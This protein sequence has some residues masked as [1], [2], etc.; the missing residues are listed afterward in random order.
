[1]VDKFR[2]VPFE[3]NGQNMRL[4]WRR[5]CFQIYDANGNRVAH[6]GMGNLPLP[7]SSEAE[8]KADYIVQSANASILPPAPPVRSAERGEMLALADG[9]EE[10]FLNGRERS[11]KELRTLNMATAQLRLAAAPPAAGSEASAWRD[12]MAQLIVKDTGRTADVLI[13]E[14]TMPAS[15]YDKAL[16]AALVAAVPPAAVRDDIVWLREIDADTDNACWVIS[17]RVDP[18]AVPFFS[19]SAYY[20]APPAAGSA[21]LREALRQLLAANL[22]SCGDGS[23]E[24]AMP[25]PERISALIDKILA[26]AAPSETAAGSDNARCPR[27]GG[28]QFISVHENLPDE[29]CPICNKDAPSGAERVRAILNKGETATDGI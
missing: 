18:D 26:L 8:A 9:L 20:S 11:D 29:P 12:F 5:S 15:V 3:H 22:L 19:G 17:N 24:G 10:M 28:D 13:V 2:I 27:C 1:M 7:M 14:Q 25:R 4:P 21:A 6:T 23:W 16:T